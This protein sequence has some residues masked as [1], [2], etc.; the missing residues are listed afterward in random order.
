MKK[1]TMLLS[2][3]A[4]AFFASACSESPMGLDT[5]SDVALH[6][7]EAGWKSKKPKPTDSNTP[8]TTESTSTT[9]RTSSGYALGM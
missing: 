8:T 5:S 3:L 1:F 4:L 2:V 6:G 9:S 7:A